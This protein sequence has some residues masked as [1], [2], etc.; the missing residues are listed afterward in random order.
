MTSKFDIDSVR[1][2]LLPVIL[3]HAVKGARELN[4]VARGEESEYYSKPDEELKNKI[5]EKLPVA[6]LERAAKVGRLPLASEITPFHLAILLD[7]LKAVREFTEKD[8][9]NNL[10]VVA[11]GKVALREGA[12]DDLTNLWEVFNETFTNLVEIA[13]SM[14]KSAAH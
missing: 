10:V 4:K 11:L 12:M 14:G 13:Y 7:S 9:A 2:K 8:V 6:P 5:L 1:K 3:M